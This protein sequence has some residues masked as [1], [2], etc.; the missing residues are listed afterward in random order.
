M[1]GHQHWPPHHDTNWYDP[2]PLPTG[3]APTTFRSGG[4]LTTCA[5]FSPTT[6]T[7]LVWP[8][9]P[10]E[11]ALYEEAAHVTKRIR[12]LHPKT[13]PAG[14]CA[15][16]GA[17]VRSVSQFSP[18][19]TKGQ[20]DSTRTHCSR[21]RNGSAADLARRRRGSAA[22]FSRMRSGSATHYTAGEARRRTFRTA[23]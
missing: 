20:R 6:T 14:Y 16:L 12:V 3:P 8:R 10:T 17:S 7:P 21:T 15:P 5:H 1:G 9:P 19:G 11:R 2:C 18:E 22:H 23:A 13:S 4:V